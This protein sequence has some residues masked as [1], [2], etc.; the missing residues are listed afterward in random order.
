MSK[1]FK[2][3]LKISSVLLGSIIL[4]A[5]A[6]CLVYMLPSDIIK[7]N[8]T[9]SID[10]FYNENIYP[11][12]ISGYKSTQLD[13]ETDAI[14][15]LG[16]IYENNDLNVLEKAMAVPHNTMNNV[17]SLCITLKNILWDR[18]EP[19]G[20]S[21]YDRYWHGYMIYLKPL[22]LLMDY[23]DIRMLNMMIQISLLLLLTLEMVRKKLTVYL[24]ALALMLVVLNPT[25]VSMSLQFSSIYY[26]ILISLLI[27]VK[28]QDYLLQDD[29]VYYYFLLSGIAVAYFDFLTYPIAAFGIPAALA[30]ILK[31]ENPGKSIKNIFNWIFCWFIGYIGMWAGKWAISSIVLDT[32]VFM[33]ALNRMN[34]HSSETAI[35]DISIS[36]FAAFWRNLRILLRWPYFLSGL[37]FL[38]LHIKNILCYIKIN[39]LKECIPFLILCLLPCIW[40]MLLRSHSAWCYWYTYRNLSVSVFSMAVFICRLSLY[41]GDIQKGNEECKCQVL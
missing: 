37:L 18:I 27:L 4:G 12:Q 24:P 28:Y 35:N 19:D 32:N 3:C 14:M 6:L 16:A 21:F 39:L 22:L 2:I 8:V 13:N 7:N 11:Q 17:S 29:R 15:L 23:A 10:I 30:L 1:Y 34:V 25:A 9:S 36:A 31:G 41:K 26:I 38:C 5:F 40:L 20:F 33:E